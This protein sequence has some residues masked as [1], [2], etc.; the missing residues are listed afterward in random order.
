MW[1]TE[2]ATKLRNS[3]LI[4]Y[5]FCKNQWLWFHLFSALSLFKALIAF[6]VAMIPTAII[7]SVIAILWEVVEFFVE[8]GGKWDNV[9]QNYGSVEK[10]K[11]DTIG[12]ILA[13]II[14]IAISMIGL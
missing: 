10:W 12:D 9:I 5:G 7:V 3:K 14:V 6:G 13:V 8:N 2:L 1:F 11:W 4:D